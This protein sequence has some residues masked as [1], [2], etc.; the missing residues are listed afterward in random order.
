VIRVDGKAVRV[1]DAQIHIWGNAGRNPDPSIAH[2][3]GISPSAGELIG[4]MD[5]AGVDRA[6][7][8]PPNFAVG[9]TEFVIDLARRYPDRFA[10]MAK[11]PVQ[12]EEHP[13]LLPWLDR[14]EVLGFRLTFARGPAVGWLTDGTADWFW[15][16]AE[17]ASAPVMVYAPGNV[18]ALIPVLTRHPGLKLIIDH[19]G[20]PSTAPPMP[21]EEIVSQALPLARFANVAVK[22]SALPC[23]TND[24]FPFPVAQRCVRLLVD[25][26]GAERVFWGSDLTRLPCSYAEA[27]RYLAEPGGLNAGELATVMGTALARFLGWPRAW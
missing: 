7:L 4:E 16:A 3:A 20:L 26:Y 14:P 21:M 15:A 1:A 5:A 19:A 12:T 18:A 17:S 6:I 8:V 10:V 2:R 25:A 23:A 24:P 13:D 22:A 9:A 27:V 11:V